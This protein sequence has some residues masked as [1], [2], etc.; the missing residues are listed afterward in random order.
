MHRPSQQINSF[1]GLMSNE[2]SQDLQLL[3]PSLII[4][5][6]GFGFV[7]KTK[8][9]AQNHI[10]LWLSRSNMEQESLLVR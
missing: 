9:C 6:Y 10:F 3:T 7:L 1:L 4:S 5:T 8:V 2:S